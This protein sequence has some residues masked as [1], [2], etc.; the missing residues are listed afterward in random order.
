MVRAVIDDH[1]LRDVLVG[2]RGLDLEGLASEGLATTGLWLYRLCLSFAS[3]AVAGRLS[4][5]VKLLPAELQAS[6]RAQLVSP[7]DEIEVLGLKE[8]AWQMA[9]IQ[10]RHRLEGRGL[11]AA[12]AEALAAAHHLGAA[13]AVSREDVGLNLRAAAEAD[14]IEFHIL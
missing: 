12:M 3:P 6:F 13:I 5:P 11:S 14:R 10:S 9:E 1:L 4:A 2:R 7:P 8:L